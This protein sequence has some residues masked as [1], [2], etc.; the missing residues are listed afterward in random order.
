VAVVALAAGFVA[1]AGAQEHPR[2]NPTI[3]L[4]Q[5]LRP[6]TPSPSAPQDLRDLPPPPMDRPTESRH[7]RIIVNSPQCLP[8]ETGFGPEDL[9]DRLPRRPRRR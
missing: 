7:F 8:G 4:N 1:S 5:I 6:D 9:Y 2:P 3:D